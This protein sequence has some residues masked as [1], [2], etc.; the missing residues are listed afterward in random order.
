MTLSMK[1]VA[2][3]KR[4]YQMQFGIELTDQEANT[5][6]RELLEL[7][8]IFSNPIP[9]EHEQYFLSLDVENRASDQA[10]YKYENTDNN[11]L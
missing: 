8:Q 10:M 5:K 1:A 4:I 3:F 9:K 2:E 6:G 7:F 11:R